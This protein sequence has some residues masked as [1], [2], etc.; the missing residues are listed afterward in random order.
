MDLAYAQAAIEVG[1]DDFL[2]VPI[3]PIEGLLR[4]R[5]LTRATNV[6][7]VGD[8]EIDL[9]AC[10]V[11]SRGYRV[12][13]SSFEFRLLACLAKRVGQTV[14]Y[15]ELIEDIWEWDPD[16]GTLAGVKDC[17]NRVRKKIESDL[18]EPQYI[19]TITREGYRLRN[20]RQWKESVPE[21]AASNLMFYYDI[22]A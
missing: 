12:R 2:V 9:A 17:I 6:V 16:G 7:R 5:K 15:A 21:T 19:I 11:S 22:E 20:Q 4:V 8:L 3:N 10:R 14:T 1:V 13:L 18:Q